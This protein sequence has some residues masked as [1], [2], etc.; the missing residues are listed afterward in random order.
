MW[1]F[2]SGNVCW[3]DMQHDS[4]QI[5]LWWTCGFCP[6]FG[7]QIQQVFMRKWISFLS[8]IFRSGIAG[9][10]GNCVQCFQEF[11]GIIFQNR[12][13][14]WQCHQQR[15][16][17][18]DFH[19]LANACRDW[20][21]SQSHPGGGDCG[22]STVVLIH[23]PLTTEGDESLFHVL[24]QLFM[25]IFGNRS[26]TDFNDSTWSVSLISKEKDG[27]I[28]LILQRTNF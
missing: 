25:S 14:I 9:P 22:P 7:H 23:V 17:V 3:E 10:C 4:H 18:L 27:P 21:F 20:S 28:L 8:Y 24:P 6:G 1:L 12:H 2:K 19:I 16:S 11:W 5:T 15:V 13:P 26:T